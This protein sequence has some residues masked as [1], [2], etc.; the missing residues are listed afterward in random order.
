MFRN[1]RME[2]ISM[3]WKKCL[4]L[5]TANAQYFG[6]STFLCIKIKSVF[7]PIL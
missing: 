1:E 4:I 6:E 3:T 2:E 5:L 7:N